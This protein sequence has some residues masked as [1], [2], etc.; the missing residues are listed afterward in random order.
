MLGQL[1]QEH[2]GREMEGVCKGVSGGGGGQNTVRKKIQMCP[3]DM[4]VSHAQTL[5]LQQVGEGREGEGCG[6]SSS[7]LPKPGT[8]DARL[9]PP[10]FS[11]LHSVSSSR[12]QEVAQCLFLFI[13]FILKGCMISHVFFL[14][15]CP[16]ELKEQTGSQRVSGRFVCLCLILS[17]VP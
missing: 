3:I 11:P 15:V 9:L 17:P 5:P 16:P 12:C 7:P 13:F 14:Y 10:P 8:D 4:T 1:K 6:A 2:H